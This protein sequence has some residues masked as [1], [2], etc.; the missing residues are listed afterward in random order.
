MNEMG[1]YVFAGFLAQVIDGALGMG[2]GVSASSLLLGGGIAPAA[3][4]AT[5]HAA[6]VFTTGFS[7][8][9]H[10]FI[11]NIDRTLFRRLLVPS[12]IGAAVGAYILVALPGDR[13]RPFVA[14][15]LLVMG[16]VIVVK[17]VRPVAPAA[18]VINHV[19]PLGFVGALVDSMG[20]GGWGPVVASTLLA[21]GNGART[22]LGT[23]N[24]VEFFVALTASI[25]FVLTL[26]VSYWR[27][28]L[29][30]AI[31]GAVAAPLSAL[32]VR[33]APA[34]PLMVL[35]GLLV[36]VLSTRTLLHALS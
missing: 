31:G 16:V 26:G 23:V 11:G 36:V 12:M 32:L 9:S 8:V 14:V 21:R 33:R 1:F 2:Y 3:A 18:A 10:H 25:V 35:V 19:G 4:S 27:I 5:V 7:A 24:A 20:G 15:Y 34:R 22:T 13:L 29:G 28:I 17:A 30:L 6:E